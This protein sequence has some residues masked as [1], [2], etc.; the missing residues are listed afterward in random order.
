MSTKLCK[1]L[2]ELG[3]EVERLHE[4]KADILI[5]P[6]PVDGVPDPSS[7]SNTR[8]E[9]DT[10]EGESRTPGP[11]SE[12]EENRGLS[13]MPVQLK[14]S[15]QEN[16]KNVF[17]TVK[18]AAVHGRYVG[19]TV[20][21]YSARW[22]NC[23]MIIQVDPLTGGDYLGLEEN[24]FEGDA[25]RKKL[26]EIYNRAPQVPNSEYGVETNFTSVRNIE[27]Q[28]FLNGGPPGVTQHV[29]LQE[30]I[31]FADMWAHVWVKKLDSS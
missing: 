18:F 14:T 24:I 3:F 6:R 19:M 22:P 17:K 12:N 25:C 1:L 15:N 5:R 31:F 13:W 8:D 10:M 27:V 26:L 21:G 23:M 7:Q 9:E 16:L 30:T 20:L 29:E 11:T 2:E 4:C 28:H